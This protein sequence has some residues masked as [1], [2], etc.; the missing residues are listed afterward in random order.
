MDVRALSDRLLRDD[1][2]AAVNVHMD[3]MGAH[4][5][6]SVFAPPE[7]GAQ[8]G[9][10]RAGGYRDIPMD[11]LLPIALAAHRQTGSRPDALDAVRRHIEEAR[12]E[13]RA[14]IR[15][16]VERRWKD[17]EQWD[18]KQAA[19]HVGISPT[20]LRS[21]T[22]RQQCP[23]AV[24]WWGRNRSGTLWDAES[25]RAWHASRPG[26]GARTDLALG[27]NAVSLAA[28]LVRL[29]AGADTVQRTALRDAWIV[30]HPESVDDSKPLHRSVGGGVGADAPRA[31]VAVQRA[32]VKLE[33]AGLIQRG[34]TTIMILDR[35]GLESAA[36]GNR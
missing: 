26:Q 19:E 36:Q 16:T 34:K 8:I 33:K 9:S 2:P 13:F 21:Y 3:T 24:P 17:R 14:E 30:R 18:D 31:R 28:I 32:L 20:T 1:E 27:D 15:S 5:R 4:L 11:E 25:I 7:P 35:A 10:W 29:A 22:S 23:P 12:D 6:G